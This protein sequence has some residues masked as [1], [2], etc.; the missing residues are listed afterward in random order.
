MQC[1][2]ATV[3]VDT[4]DSEDWQKL[5]AAVSALKNPVLDESVLLEASPIGRYLHTDYI[6]SRSSSH[7]MED[8]TREDFDGGRGYDQYPLRN[9]VRRA[10]EGGILQPYRIATLAATD[11]PVSSP[12]AVGLRNG[13]GNMVDNWVAGLPEGGGRRA[14]S[15]TDPMQHLVDLGEDLVIRQRQEAPSAA[16]EQPGG[17]KRSLSKAKT[18]PNNLR[19]EQEEGARLSSGDVADAG[20]MYKSKLNDDGG[21]TTT[22][23]L[24]LSPMTSK[25]GS[26]EHILTTGEFSPTSM[27]SSPLGG[28][29]C[30]SPTTPMTPT[31][32]LI[33]I[34][35]NKVQKGEGLF[36]LFVC[37][38]HP[39]PPPFFFLF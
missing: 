24:S 20:P 22:A 31:S 14:R 37:L 27:M 4:Y 25:P 16:G 32:K 2:F 35:M 17:D 7:S 10:S 26:P 9:H 5:K 21:D 38:T 15:H 39:P 18:L 8:V 23:V 13:S 34:Y 33:K 3:S 12:Y 1:N 29:V 6:R 28:D 11:A 36:V 19:I 30:Q